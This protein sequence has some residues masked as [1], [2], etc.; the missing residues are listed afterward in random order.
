MMIKF[1][2]KDKDKLIEKVSPNFI[3]NRFDKNFEDGYELLELTQQDEKFYIPIHLEDNIVDLGVYLTPISQESFNELIKFIF[4]HYTDAYGINIEQSLND[5]KGL[6]Q[7]DNYVVE[8]PNTAEEFIRSRGRKTRLHLKQYIKYIYRDFR[9]DF[10]IFDKDIPT[11]I[12]SQYFKFKSETIGHKYKETEQDY[13][14]NFNITKSIVLYLNDE[15]AAISLIVD[16]EDGDNKNAYYENFSYDK[17]YSKYSL[18]TVITYYTVKYLIENGYDRFC[19]GAGDY[20][21][22]RNLS[23]KKFTTFNGIIRRKLRSKQKLK[24]IMR[25]ILSLKTTKDFHYLKFLGLHIK[26]RRFR[27]NCPLEIN[28][29]TKCLMVAPHPDDEIIG[30]GALMIKYSNNF[31]CIIM[32]SS[33]VSEEGDMELAKKRSKIRVEEFNNVMETIGIKNHRIFETVGTK[34]RYDNEMLE[35]LDNYCEALKDL[36]QYD[37][38]FLPHPKDGHHEHKFV[39]NKLFKKIIEKLGYNPNTKIVFYEVWADMENPNVFFDTSK[40]GFLYGKTSYKPYQTANSKLLGTNDY[41]LLDWKYEIL[42]MYPSQWKGMSI[43]IT[44]SMRTKC[45]NNGQNPIWRFRV[46]DIKKYI[47]K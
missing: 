8:L 28:K 23:T 42:S 36:K 1:I 46:E 11:K 41:S 30:A 13:L 25:S 29:G 9:V 26:K 35:M 20:L 47:R 14:K 32:G 34:L 12:I 22:K 21:Y 3:K 18:G 2:K 45:L 7:D 27:Q 38:I 39:T 40:D 4:D 6:N 31:D 10:K 15:I 5:Y 43:F 16:S 37:Y 33:G 19:L 44:Q 17:K 24:S